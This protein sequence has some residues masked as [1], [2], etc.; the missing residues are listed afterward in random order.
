MRYLTSVARIVLAFVALAV[1][2]SVPITAGTQTPGALLATDARGDLVELPLRHT[3]VRVEIT[4]D[5]QD[6]R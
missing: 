2:T 4:A 3:T 1:A 5:R 6:S